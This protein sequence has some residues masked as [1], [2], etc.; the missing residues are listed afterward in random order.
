MAQPITIPAGTVDL[1]A[2]GFPL[3][4]F[5]ELVEE[6]VELHIREFQK[7]MFNCRIQDK[8]HLMMFFNMTLKGKA[9]IWYHGLEVETITSIDLF[10]GAF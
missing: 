4:I 7:L 6:D 2:L 3:P 8:G 10:Y 1:P 5:N 9:A